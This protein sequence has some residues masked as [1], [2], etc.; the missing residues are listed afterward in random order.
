[1]L[2]GTAIVA[3]VLLNIGLYLMARTSIQER[4]RRANRARALREAL[5]S[6]VRR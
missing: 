5:N 3:V 4:R 2:R 1:M 6:D